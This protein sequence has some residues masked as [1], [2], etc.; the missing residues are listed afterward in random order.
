MRNV[1]P[2]I[3]AG[4][5]GVIAPNGVPCYNI[6]DGQRTEYDFREGAYWVPIEDQWM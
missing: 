2:D 1:P 5:N 4:F 6:A 3:R